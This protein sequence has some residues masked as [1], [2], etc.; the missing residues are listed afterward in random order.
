MATQVK[1]TKDL[2]LTDK[3]SRLTFTQ[4][5]ELLGGPVEGKKLLYAGGK[6]PA[7]NLKEQVTL[8]GDMFRLSLPAEDAIVTITLRQD[9]VKRL[10]LNCDKCSETC[11]HMGTAM[12][13]ILESKVVLGLARAPEERKPVESLS[14]EQLIERAM[15]ERQQ[16]AKEEKMSV[17]SANKAATTPWGDY[18]VTSRL[19][20]KSYRVALRGTEPGDSYCTC[21]DY[22]TNTLGT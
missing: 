9:K 1:K 10:L 15:T 4:A 12:W 8:V 7:E 6:I 21:P 13:T 2:T 14:E 11:V 18:V 20:G 19:S 5:C 22:R 17:E 3:L 16:R